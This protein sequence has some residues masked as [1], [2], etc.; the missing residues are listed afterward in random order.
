MDK[1]LTIMSVWVLAASGIQ[2]GTLWIMKLS[3]LPLLNGLPYDRYVSTC[4]RIKMHVFHPIAVWNGVIAAGIGV[5]AAV[6]APGVGSAVLFI[7]GSVGMLVVGLT[8]EGVNRPI[9][10]Q[11]EK[12]STDTV[13]DERWAQKRHTWHLAH[14]VRTYGGILAVAGYLAAIL[15]V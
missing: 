15:T 2:L 5:V 3:I 12:W 6:A 8:S 7:V 9:W 4:Q 11:I 1:T 14:V 10:R 13:D